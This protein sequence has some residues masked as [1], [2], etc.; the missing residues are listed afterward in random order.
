[1]GGNGDFE[2]GLRK[3]FLFFV[4]RLYSCALRLV[5]W[6]Q[7][8]GG[9]QVSDGLRGEGARNKASGVGQYCG[10]LGVRC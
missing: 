9:L 10:V 5:T 7:V 6:S 8:V 2:L 3:F 1:M 4:V